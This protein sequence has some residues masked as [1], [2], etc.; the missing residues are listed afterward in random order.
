MS[1]FNTIITSRLVD[2]EDSDY[3]QEELNEESL[4]L[5]TRVNCID[6]IKYKANEVDYLYF[7]RDVQPFIQDDEFMIRLLKEIIRKY[8]LNSLKL[9]LGDS[10]QSQIY[11]DH[12]TSPPLNQDDAPITHDDK[13]TSPLNNDIVSSIYF[14]KRYLM[15]LIED[16]AL[17]ENIS[18]NEFMDE[19]ITPL[20]DDDSLN[21]R[22]SEFK[23]SLPF[24]IHMPR[25][26]Q[27]AF[28][29]LDRESYEL[30]ISS[31]FKEYDSISVDM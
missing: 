29:Y 12:V 13:I 20:K 25:C 18:Y 15:D 3:S 28:K 21:L 19:I 22:D 17:T 7:W 14:I 2:E 4:E 9:F 31:L 23:Y 24:T 1:S 16:G 30:F 11:N 6:F 10:F 5:Q 27:F 26:L 8:H